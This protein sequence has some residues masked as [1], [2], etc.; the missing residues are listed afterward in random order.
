MQN[1]KATAESLLKLNVDQLGNCISRGVFIAIGKLIWN[2]YKIGILDLASV[3]TAAFWV[4]KTHGP[5]LAALAVGSL[6]G[7]F[8]PLLI[9]QKPNAE[10]GKAVG[11]LLSL[12]AFGYQV[13]ALYSSGAAVVLPFL[14]YVLIGNAAMILIGVII[15]IAAT[16]LKR[17]CHST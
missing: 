4:G 10:A 2:G 9:C 11:S 6:F 14:G 12:A 1:Q 17:C 3:K 8:L 16:A 15:A 7:S 13:Y 5:I